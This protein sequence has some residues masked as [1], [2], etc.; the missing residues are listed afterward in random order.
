VPVGLK[1]FIVDDEDVAILDIRK[2][3]FQAAEAAASQ[4]GGE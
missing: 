2:L 3:E 4:G 1:T